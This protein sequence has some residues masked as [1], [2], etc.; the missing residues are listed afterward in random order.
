MILTLVFALAVAPADSAQALEEAVHAFDAA[1]ASMRAEVRQQVVQ[2]FEERKADVLKTYEDQITTLEVNERV[3]RA[4]AIGQFEHFLAEHPAVPTYTPDAMFRLAE[5]YFERSNDAYFQAMREWQ[6]K[7]KEAQARAGEEPK[8]PLQHYQ[9]TI[10]LYQNLIARFPTYRLLDGA[11]YLLGYCQNEQ[12][13]EEVAAHTFEA[14][15]ERFPQ[16][17][18]VA[19][20]DTRIGEFYFDA[21][22]LPKAAIAYEQV[23]RYPESPFYDKALYKLAWTYY[24]QDRF[25]DAVKHFTLLVDFADKSKAQGGKSGSDLRQEAIEYMGISFAE[26]TW[27]GVEKAKIYFASIGGRLWEAEVYTM[28]GDVYFDQTKYPDAVA[29]YSL[30]LARNPNNPDAPKLQDKIVQAY[31]RVRDFDNAAKARER[32]ADAYAD[33]SAWAKANGDQPDALAAARDISE[34]SLLAAAVFH[35]R[36]AQSFREAKKNDQAKNEY[37]AA[38]QG[39]AAY[40]K[41]FAAAKNR[42]DLTYYLADCLYYSVQFE[43][44]AVAYAR[45]RDDESEDTHR[46]PAAFSAV[47]SRERLIQVMQSRKEL[48][49][50]PVLKSTERTVPVKATPLPPIRLAE[51]QDCDAY[52]VRAPQSP[53]A[54]QIAY[55]AAEVFFVYD[56]LDEARRRFATVITDYPKNEVARFAANLT[57]ESYLAEKR[58]AEVEKFSRV[59][60][61]QPQ[62]AS[63]SA[64]FASDLQKFKLG[65]MF[66]Q[67]EDLD[68]QKQYEAAAAAYIR[69]VDENPTSPFADKA[70]NNAAV[71]YEKV[72]R[73]ESATKL[74]ERVAHD[75]PNSPLADYAVFRV[76]VNAE[77]FYDFNKAIESYELLVD[78]YPKSQH[79]ADALYNACLAL[80]NTQQYARAETEEQR[81][82]QLFP[83]RDD[84]PEL[85]FRSA[86]AAANAGEP[87]RAVKTYDE[88]VRRYGRAKGQDDRVVEAHFQSAQLADQMNNSGAARREYAAALSE[89]AHRGKGQIF[90]ARSQFEATELEFREYEA[91]K[92]EGSSKAQKDGIVRRSGRLTKL[93]DNYQRVFPYKQVE[94]TLASL[95]RIGNLYETF[96]DTLFQAPPP[97]EIKKL[98]DEY[99]EEYRVLLEEKATPLEDKAVDAYKRTIEEAKKSGVANEWTKRT[100]RSL[101]KLRKKEFPLQKDAKFAFEPQPLAIPEVPGRAPTPAQ[102]ASQPTSQPASQKAAP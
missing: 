82:A 77:R 9:E 81:Y 87:S 54:P 2:R 26:E 83:Q 63:T 14:L 71:N 101:N 75:F 15:V 68:S 72:R 93:R 58:W 51:V 62:G 18:F 94:W 41:R 39:Y 45:V 23:L 92:I 98:G 76:G 38:A 27:G 3:R 30:S 25:D 37:A 64:A 60:L 67:A 20:A 99:V 8:Q 16:S 66:K 80:E 90:A 43:P 86:K 10:A 5:L 70:L 49:S 74:Y 1:A 40:L 79:R 65:A 36:Q 95:Y 102:A 96:A 29:S 100:L 50:R 52:V 84:A 42:Y 55:K 34:R 91:I 17:R 28:L 56:Q 57:I 35:H 78:K 73:F 88:Y 7:L 11:F 13:D 85:F 21:N 12:G 59:M 48:D 31:E 61:A 47:L 33:G 53:K 44:A 69:L 24:R 6:S 32:L 4:E 19:E 89:A 46:E 97:P 22:M